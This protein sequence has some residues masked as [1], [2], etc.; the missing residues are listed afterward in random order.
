MPVQI[1][2]TKLLANSF[3]RFQNAGGSRSPAERQRD[4]VR[5]HGGKT[6]ISIDAPLVFVGYGAV[7]P[8]EKWDDYKGVDMKGKILVMMV[9][10]PQPTAEEPNRFAGKAY[11]YY[12]RWMYKFEEACA[13]ARPARC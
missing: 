11:T 1:E 9:N 10:D 7:A 6:D 5:H 2:G 13:R 4:R 12:G 8:E 3:V